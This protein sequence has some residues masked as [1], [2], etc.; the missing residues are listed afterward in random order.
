MV[1]PLGG[2]GLQDLPGSEAPP[3]VK[4]SYSKWWWALATFLVLACIG[5]LVAV[6]PGGALIT[7]II[8][9]VAIYMVKDDCARMSQ[10]CVLMFS[11]IC[12]MQFVFDLITLCG[13]VGGRQSQH[14]T[15]TV[16][17]GTKT[18]YTTVVETHPFFAK[19]QGWHY[20]FQSAMLITTPVAMLASVVLACASYRCYPNPLFPE[21]GAEGGFMGGGAQGGYEQGFGTFGAPA[22][23]RPTSRLV[24]S[25]RAPA[26]VFGGTGQRLGS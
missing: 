21:S 10:Y 17:D 2:A 26:P 22:S 19:E 25:D 9:A 24:S 18:S 6:D 11:I 15:S 12:A 8:A 20:N 1:L 14:T 13:N 3:I 7:G 5:R 23:G 4:D 16:V